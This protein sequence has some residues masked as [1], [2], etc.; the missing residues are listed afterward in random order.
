MV[1]VVAVA[2]WRPR[3]RARAEG[4]ELS[5]VA[6]AV[7]LLVA[8]VFATAVWPGARLSSM[9]FQFGFFRHNPMSAQVIWGSCPRAR[10][11]PGSW[12]H[13]PR[14]DDGF[15]V[16]PIG[17]GGDFTVLLVGD[18]V[19]SVGMPEILADAFTASGLH[20]RLLDSSMGGYDQADENCIVEQQ[21][22]R[23]KPDLVILG[24][25]LNDFAGR[26]LITDLGGG[27][28]EYSWG[29]ASTSG[30]RGSIAFPCFWRAASTGSNGIAST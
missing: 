17:G 22:Q 25:C 30:S 14:N 11:R 19:V 9:F 4:L 24:L 10:W 28:R 3:W 29:A 1:V 15:A 21:L 5:L 7:T 18:S 26:P 16:Y 23:K 20:G 2:L 27:T 12:G 6:F 8:D 13:V